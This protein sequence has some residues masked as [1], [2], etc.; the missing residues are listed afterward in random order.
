M[1]RGNVGMFG[2]TPPI[3][4]TLIAKAQA[5]GGVYN[6]GLMGNQQLLNN[7]IQTA[8]PTPQPAPQQDAGWYNKDQSAWQNALNV[9]ENERNQQNAYNGWAAEQGNWKY[10]DKGNRYVDYNNL[11]T[12]E[13]KGPKAFGL[14]GA[15]SG[16]DWGNSEGNDG[17]MQEQLSRVRQ[18]DPNAKLELFDREE[19]GGEGG[20]QMKKHYRINFD[21][22]KLPKPAFDAK[23]GTWAVAG[24]QGQHVM[25]ENA[26]RVDPNYGIYT[27]TKN[28]KQDKSWLDTVGPMAPILLAA[29][30]GGMGFLPS[31]GRQVLGSVNDLGSGKGFNPMQYGGSVMPFLKGL[32]G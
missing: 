32:G 10:D 18:F 21:E 15:T 6:T 23:P 17:L 13:F 5:N 28:V 14:N 7:A 29:L 31:L 4:P 1:P 25:N 24:P 22:S 27:P 2:A 19:G 16:G 8:Q 12:P 3:D 20:G 9:A 26:M 30:T 11:V